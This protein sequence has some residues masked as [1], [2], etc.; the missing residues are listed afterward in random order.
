MEDDDSATLRKMTLTQY[1]QLDGDEK[2]SDKK[3]DSKCM[4]KIKNLLRDISVGQY[5]T[6]LF[7][8]EGD[9]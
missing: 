2:K 5:N 1:L 7:H 3:E 6:K 4:K 8:E 9:S